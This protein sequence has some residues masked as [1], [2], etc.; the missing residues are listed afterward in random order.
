MG[1]KLIK[2]GRTN[3]FILLG[4]KLTWLDALSLIADYVIEDGKRFRG[5]FKSTSELFA[6]RLEETWRIGIE[7]KAL[8]FIDNVFSLITSQNVTA[9]KLA[10]EVD[11]TNEGLIT[12]Q[13]VT[14][15]KL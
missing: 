4:Q 6:Y 8:Y 1:S 12:S 2:R 13:N 10:I 5:I 14:A 15:P 11:E 7:P 9:P 3:G